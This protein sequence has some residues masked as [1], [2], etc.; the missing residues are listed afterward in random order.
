M[1]PQ[2]CYGV[3]KRWSM[4]QAGWSI[5][6]TQTEEL[7]LATVFRR[8][9]HDDPHCNA[10]LTGQGRIC[11]ARAQG[12]HRMQAP[13]KLLYVKYK[14]P[15]WPTQQEGQ[16]A[17]MR[18]LAAVNNHH[19]DNHHL[20]NHWG[21]QAAPHRH[22]WISSLRHPHS[23]PGAH[24]MLR[25]CHLHSS[26]ISVTCT[27][28]IRKKRPLKQTATTSTPRE[29]SLSHL[30]KCAVGLGRRQTLRN[31]LHDLRIW[32]MSLRSWISFCKDPPGRIRPFHR[33]KKWRTESLQIRAQPTWIPVQIS[34]FRCRRPPSWQPP[35]Q[36]RKVALMEFQQCS[37]LASGILPRRM[38]HSAQLAHTWLHQMDP[39]LLLCCPLRP[40]S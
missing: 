2:T 31:L 29:R 6:Q 38:L 17:P 35:K 40:W 9:H 12:P 5:Q 10:V 20:D 15:L 14:S 32:C 24:R 19:L 25:S 3:L 8:R 33:I 28:R 36:H 21:A 30:P 34:S 23:W 26:D 7:L 4:S 18:S 22:K 13:V 11:V 39:T 37:S 16:A 1:G 27:R